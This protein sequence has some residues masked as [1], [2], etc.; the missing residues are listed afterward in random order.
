MVFGPVRQRH[1]SGLSCDLDDAASPAE[2]EDLVRG[3]L[4]RTLKA[5]GYLAEAEKAVAA[6][7]LITAQCPGGEPVGTVYGP[8]KPLPAFPE[9]L[10]ELA[11]KALDRVLADE[12]GLS[13]GWVDPADARQWLWSIKALRDA[14]DPPPASLD[15]PLFDL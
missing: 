1:G 10:R 6:A 3:V 14:L 9:E 2:R 15:V 11:A 12:S 13:E 8:R 4:T 5:T 7:A